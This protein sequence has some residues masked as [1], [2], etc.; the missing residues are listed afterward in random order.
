MGR[1]SGR[2]AKGC[3]GREVRRCPRGCLHTLVQKGEVKPGV[4]VRLS[5]GDT[6]RW[7]RRTACRARAGD[8]AGQPCV[9]PDPRGKGRRGGGDTSL[10][11]HPLI[12]EDFNCS[13]GV[14]RAP[15][16]CP[17]TLSAFV[18]GAGRAQG[19]QEQPSTRDVGGGGTKVL[20]QL[21]AGAAGGPHRPQVPA[22]RAAQLPPMSSRLLRLPAP[23][24]SR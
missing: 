17:R 2:D 18:V 21:G 12:Y 11:R 22:P 16:G 1:G 14:A 24:S 8:T 10:S 4:R 5:R 6:W 7:L 23:W 9:S 15:R 3:P 20:E 13:D 19:L